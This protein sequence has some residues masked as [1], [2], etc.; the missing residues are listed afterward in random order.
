MRI[1]TRRQGI[2]YLDT[3]LWVPKEKINVDATK[4]ALTLVTDGGYTGRQEVLELWKES[5]YHLLLP[6]AFWDLGSLTFEV[7]DCRPQ[8]FREVAFTSRMKPDHRPNAEGVL[9]PTGNDVQKLSLRA[10]QKSQGGT[11]QLSCGMGKT[12]IALEN[13]ARSRTPAIV[14]VDNTQLLGQWEQ[15]IHTF[16]TVPG[17]IGKMAQG[18]EDWEG[19]GIVLAT[20]QTISS[21]ADKLPQEF[22]NYF[23]GAYFDEGHHVSAPV[24]SRVVSMFPG[25]RFS[26]TATPERSDGQH[27]IAAFHVG[28]VLYKYLIPTM[29]PKIVFQWTSM[30]LDLREPRVARS[31][32]DKNGEVHISKVKSY[33]GSW[34][35]RLTFVLDA[36]EK[37]KAAGRK[38]L[39]L[40][41]SVNEVANL[42]AMSVRNRD[43]SLYTDVTYP[44]PADVGETLSPVHLTSKE[45]KKL[46]KDIEKLEKKGTDEG[47]LDLLRQTR[48]QHEVAKKL[49]SL[50]LRRK[51]TFLEDLVEEAFL[52]R[53]ATGDGYGAMTFGVPA[54]KRQWFLDNCSVVFA[55]TK[56]GKEGLDCDALDTIICSSLFSDKNPLQQLLG[57]P[58]RLKEGKKEPVVVFLV[59]GVGQCIGMSRKLMTHLRAWPPDE[60]GPYK[61]DLVGYPNTHN[62]IT[63]L[64]QVFGA[65]CPT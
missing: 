52:L 13:I 37:A 11:L 49:E 42:L 51:K 27:V 26:L 20:Y 39:V 46:D 2:G 18:V 21:K 43:A 60:G 17:G 47:Y 38:T 56:Y 40:T 7:V 28:R 24:Y 9:V 59:D 54:K 32:L 1:I 25:N 36:T 41:D 23:G 34:R 45:R 64:S 19:R 8:E 6:R 44:V 22:C 5:P 12:A 35:E 65:P 48:R 15:A 61:Y 31:V 50:Y 57:R 30:E 55:I 3:W 29:I 63:D 33:F 53:E 4:S 10:L 62:P 14:M 16:L 58:T